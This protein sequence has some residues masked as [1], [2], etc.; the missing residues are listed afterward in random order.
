MVPRSTSRR[1]AHVPKKDRQMWRT[2]E[3]TRRRGRYRPEGGGEGKGDQ[4]ERDKAKKQEGREKG[5]K[6]KSYSI[7]AEPSADFFLH[8]ACIVR[9]RHAPYRPP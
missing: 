2:H 8:N 6:R 5:E 4:R 1:K 7:L 3:A 9:V